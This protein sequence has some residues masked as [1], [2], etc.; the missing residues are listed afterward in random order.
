[1]SEEPSRSSFGCFCSYNNSPLQI[2]E[3]SCPNDTSFVSTSAVHVQKPVALALEK[4]TAATA[5]VSD[6]DAAEGDEQF[7]RKKLREPLKT[8]TVEPILLKPTAR[9]RFRP[10]RS[11]LWWSAVEAVTK[12]K[13]IFTAWDGSD[14]DDDGLQLSMPFCCDGVRR[15]FSHSLA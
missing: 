9:L 7:K 13:L 11:D 1:M 10:A 12:T 15:T 4:L 8:A 6:D 3:S 2:R 5:E 14:G